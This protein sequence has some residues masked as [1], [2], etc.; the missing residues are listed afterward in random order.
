MCL[1]NHIKQIKPS[2][3]SCHSLSLV[4]D[5]EKRW[6]G[7]KMTIKSGIGGGGIDNDPLRLTYFL[8]E[9]YKHS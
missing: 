1:S 8:N 7:E 2:S 4:N 9:P 5:L 6:V 3:V